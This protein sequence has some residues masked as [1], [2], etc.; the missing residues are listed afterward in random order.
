MFRFIYSVVFYL[1]TP[2]IILRLVI[3]GLAAPNYRKRWGQRFGFFTPSESSKETIWLHAVSVGET[4]A[5]VPLVKAL[6]EKYP[7]RRL[8]ITC[9]TPTGSERITAAFGDSVDHSYAPYDTPDAV[10]RFLKRVQ[11]K[12]L[13]I[14]ET[15][16]WPNTVA[17]CYKRQIP[18]ILANGRLS[19]KSARGYA[20]VSKLSGPMVAQLSAVA[21][22]HGDDG[23]RFTALGLPVEKLH[24]TGNIKFDLELNAQ[25]RLSAEALRQQWDGTNQRPV[26]LAA[27]THR[28]EDEI[29]LQAFSLIKQSVNNALLVLVPRH[30]ERFNQVG[31]LCLDAGYSLARRSNN[32]STDNADIL[33]GDTMGELMTFFGACD[34]AFVGGSLVSNGGHNMI[35]PAAWGKPTLSGLSVFNFAEVSRLLAEAGGLSLVEDAAA[36]AES[37]IVLMKNP[38]QAQQM[39]L[40]AQQVAEANR[41]ALERLLA[42]IDNSLSQ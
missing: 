6:Q 9:M 39:G 35:E 5:A 28:G 41:G 2:L 34:I 15:E 24:I 40:S 37:V 1:I 3:R 22:Q 23:G 33:L 29:I 4:L 7:E 17:A 13:I 38:E 10:A 11:P 42:V 25:I 36:L 26:L 8:L 18:V 32:D 19:E 30:P 16:L 27:S 12:M 31:D 20:R 14:M 21:A